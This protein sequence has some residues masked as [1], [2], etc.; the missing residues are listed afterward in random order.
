MPLPSDALLAR[1]RVPRASSTR[2]ITALETAMQGLTLNARQPVALEIA[3]TA[4]ER[5]WL[6]RA[7]TPVALRHLVAQ[8]QARYPQAEIEVPEHD[9]LAL[10][11]G[12]VAAVTELC[13]GAASYLPLRTL[14][15]R[16]L[17]KEGADPLLG[18]LAI[19]EQLPSDTRAVAQLVLLPLPASWS[20]AY[21]RRTVEHPLEQERVRQRV[22]VQQGSS[23][24][25]SPH[26]LV[27]LL[28]LVIVLL[29]WWRFQ[30]SILAHTPAW[31]LRAGTQLLH[32]KAPHLTSGEQAQLVG[33]RLGLFLL[34]FSLA[35]LVVWLRNHFGQTTIYDMRL[36]DEKTARLA[37]RVRLRLVAIAEASASTS[38]KASAHPGSSLLSALPQRF[39]RLHTWL[40]LPPAILWQTSQAV[41]RQQYQMRE[42]EE[43]R[44]EPCQ[45]VLDLLAAAYRQYHTAAGGSFV[46]RSF[47]NRRASRLLLPTREGGAVWAADVARS[48]HLL[49]VADIATLWHLPQ[50]QDLADLNYVPRGRAR[51]FLVPAELTTGQG[52]HLGHSSHAG[53]R[54]PVVL[55]ASC[56]RQ[57]LLAVASTGK[58]KSTLF[59]HLAC[60]AMQD[61]KRCVIVVEPHGDLIARLLGSIPASRQ[62]DVVVIDLAATDFPVGINP[63]DMSLGRSRDKA[64]D[65]LVQMGEA[66]WRTSWGPRTENVFEMT[67]K[68]LAEANTSLIH[69]DPQSGPT[70]QYTLLDIVPLLEH[71]SFRHAVLEQVHDPVLLDWW[72][73]YYESKERR[74]QEEITSSVITKLTKFASSRVTRN[75]LGQPQTTV[76]FQEVI[77]QGKIV[78]ISTAS[79]VV[80]SDISALVGATLLGLFQTTLAEQAHYSQEQRRSVLA[81]IDEFQVFG[82][83]NYQSM[84]AELRKYGG[85]FGLATQ[86]LAYLDSFDRTLRST[87]LANIDHLFAFTMAAEDACLLR[88]DG[89]EEADITQLDDYQCYARLSLRGQRLPLFSLNLNAPPQADENQ[90][91]LLRFASQQ[92]DAHPVGIVE[93]MLRD[94]LARRKNAAPSKAF[95][96]EDLSGTGAVSG[97]TGNRSTNDTDSAKKRKNNKKR[98]AG[99]KA[100]A[101]S[102]EAPASAS[103]V[104]PQVHLMYEEEERDAHNDH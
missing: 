10:Q 102:S 23:A 54:V 94:A 32:G 43:V 69:T 90:A 83:V 104:T 78:L 99:N 21:R 45:E 6:L 81:I 93:A 98:G 88:L 35:F 3:G 84:L 52:Y 67:A 51:T 61:L 5:A 34:L 27:S 9:P 49:S 86:S 76:N 58:G 42:E 55:P 56:L 101:Q 44:R 22:S 85:S 19:F 14:S 13:P 57:N 71:T 37:Y 38:A 17:L 87:V 11:P 46:T 75:I 20:R 62:D 92:R 74:M 40:A 60:A 95:V 1:I 59:H 97:S 18:L 103:V 50:A 24:A 31:L 73:F 47:S 48:K 33:L 41:L 80:G 8:I 12:E 96:W 15:E 70:R 100:A 4:T 91:R 63:L 72:A 66:Q 64:V 25:P 16:E 77:R 7:T 68:T 29:L 26:K 28:V 2:D 36:V 39:A 79:G 82:G 30:K 89:V 65:N 53:R